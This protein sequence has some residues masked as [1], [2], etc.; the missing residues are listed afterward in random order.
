MFDAVAKSR[1]NVRAMAIGSER[2]PLVQPSGPTIVTVLDQVSLLCA[3]VFL[4]AGV[5][6]AWS[7]SRYLAKYRQVHGNDPLQSDRIGR[8]PWLF[9]A[10]LPRLSRDLHAAY[11]VAQADSE[12]ERL[13][14]TVQRWQ[15]LAIG[16]WALL[17][18]LA[19]IRL[20]GTA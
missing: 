11:T 13:R 14:R 2:S 9:F 8:A 3:L 1:R 17:M 20:T 10:L 4:L 6:M 7:Q 5:L 16:A 19:V 15:R 18:A 12:L